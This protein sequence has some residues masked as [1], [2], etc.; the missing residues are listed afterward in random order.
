MTETKRKEDPPP[1]PSLVGRGV[2]SLTPGPSPVGRGVWERKTPGH[3]VV[4][5]SADIFG[6]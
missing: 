6:F 4:D 1:C 3:P 5:V 2:K